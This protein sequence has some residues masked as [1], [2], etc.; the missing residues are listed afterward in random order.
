VG[1]NPL[2][3]ID[4]NR[5]KMISID[6]EKFVITLIVGS[7]PRTFSFESKEAMDKAFKEWIERSQD[8]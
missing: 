8:N 4:W 2:E 3:L 7:Q 5:V 6:T 1:R